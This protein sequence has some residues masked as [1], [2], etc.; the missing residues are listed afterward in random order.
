MHV[1]LLPGDVSLCIKLLSHSGNLHV[2]MEKCCTSIVI[3]FISQVFCL[4]HL[5]P[6]ILS[7]GHAYAK[8]A[9]VQLYFVPCK[10]Y[11]RMSECV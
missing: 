5:P 10:T 9:T 7:Y 3:L 11:H 1:L 8:L 6:L 2:C 4:L